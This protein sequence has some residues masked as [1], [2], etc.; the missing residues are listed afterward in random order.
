MILE[1]KKTNKTRSR[2]SQPLF[3]LASR[4]LRS[5]RG[6]DPDLEQNIEADE[7][8][9]RGNVQDPLQQYHWNIS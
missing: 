4:G 9:N 7:L 6:R 3:L 2:M 1:P 5:D 8:Q